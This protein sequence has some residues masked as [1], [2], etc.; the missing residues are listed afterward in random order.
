MIMKIESEQNTHSK[1][2]RVKIPVLPN[3]VVKKSIRDSGPSVGSKHSGFTPGT[4]IFTH[5]TN[6][7]WLYRSDWFIGNVNVYLLF[8]FFIY[9]LLI[10]FLIDKS[11]SL[12]EI[13][14]L[15]TYII[16]L[17]FKG[18]LNLWNLWNR[19]MEQK[20]L[21]SLQPQLQELKKELTQMMKCSGRRAYLNFL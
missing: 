12:R 20:K 2:E 14:P 8:T 3:N 15:L 10:V 5:Y 17:Y 1:G 13:K 9:T 21:K 18:P 19:P 4:P 11:E 6:L 7:S 16:G